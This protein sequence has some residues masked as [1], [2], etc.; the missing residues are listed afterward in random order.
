MLCSKGPAV[1]SAR[2]LKKLIREAILSEMPMIKPGGGMDPSHLEKLTDMID[3]GDEA[4]ARQADELASM[5]GHDSDH[6]SQDLKRY[7]RVSIMGAA[8]EFAH[9]LTDKDI[10]MLMNI[11]GK[12]LHYGLYSWAGFGFEIIGPNGETSMGIPPDDFYEMFI[13]VAARKKGG[14]ITEDDYAEHEGMD[15]GVKAVHDLVVAVISLSKSTT[16]HR[17]TMEDAGLGSPIGRTGHY[18]WWEPEYEK[19]WQAG[20]LKIKGYIE[21][22]PWDLD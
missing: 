12:D 8:G 7:D 17:D 16:V 14:D 19:L 18:E 2:K 10:N 15:S 20:K 22:D 5:V 4:D 13:R 9:Y 1:I 11:A 21:P 3:T 6:F